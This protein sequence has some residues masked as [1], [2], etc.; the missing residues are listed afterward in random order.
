MHKAIKLLISAGKRTNSPT[1]SGLLGLSVR[2]VADLPE[3]SNPPLPPVCMFKQEVWDVI[4]TDSCSRDM[5]APPRDVPIIN[6]LIER[7][8]AVSF[9]IPENIHGFF[10]V[11]VCH[12]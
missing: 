9:S 8:L 2:N 10:Q 3:Q 6:R 7:R 12:P 4:R 1:N 5:C 11:K